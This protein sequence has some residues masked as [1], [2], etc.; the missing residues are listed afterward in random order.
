M[1]IHCNRVLAIVRANPG[2]TAKQVLEEAGEYVS[3]RESRRI[4]AQL[5]SMQKRGLVRHR[6][7]VETR[8]YRWD[9][10]L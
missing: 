10:L 1:A 4:L 8:P 3:P 5:M 9:A 7:K 6:R 2:I